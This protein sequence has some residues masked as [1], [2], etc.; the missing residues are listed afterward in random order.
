MLRLTKHRMTQ[1]PNGLAVVAA[2]LLLVTAVAGVN[3]TTRVEAEAKA[4]AA[5]A[6]AVVAQVE[7]DE[8]AVRDK[9]FKMSLFLFRFTR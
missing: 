8:S 2:L 5:R 1:V 6:E 4:L 9:G 3:R 7:A